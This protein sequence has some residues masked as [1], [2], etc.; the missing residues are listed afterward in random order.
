MIQ[1]AMVELAGRDWEGWF[2]LQTVLEGC[3]LAKSLDLEMC[4]K[5]RFQ[6]VFSISI[7]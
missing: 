1:N 7:D 2:K 5:D 3:E 6:S 4:S